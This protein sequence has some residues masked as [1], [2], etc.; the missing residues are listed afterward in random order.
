MVQGSVDGCRAHVYTRVFAQ[1][2]VH[3]CETELRKPG[4]A[5]APRP[6]PSTVAPRQDPC[7]W[8]DPREWPRPGPAASRHTLGAPFTSLVLGPLSFTGDASQRGCEN[9]LSNTTGI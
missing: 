7:K 4:G 1:T 9:P 3:T 6:R 5:L 8:Q 2:R